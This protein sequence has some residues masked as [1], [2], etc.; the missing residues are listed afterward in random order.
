MTE[1]L[2]I[3]VILVLYVV[4]TAICV[5]VIKFGP[6]A[7]RRRHWQKFAKKLKEE[8]VRQNALKKANVIDIFRNS[9]KD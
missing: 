5:V 1:H 4:A 8:Q 6:G 7:K 2:F 3:Y 9:R